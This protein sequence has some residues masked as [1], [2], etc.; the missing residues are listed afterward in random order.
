MKN[1]VHCFLPGIVGHVVDT[2]PNRF[3]GKRFELMA[4]VI[5]AFLCERQWNAPTMICYYMKFQHHHELIKN[6]DTENYELW[7][8]AL[9]NGI[10]HN[11]PIDFAIYA[12]DGS[13]LQEFQLK[14]FG[15]VRSDTDELIAYINAM[16]NQYAPIDATC[17]VWVTDIAAIDFLKVNNEMQ[18]ADFPFTALR[19]FGVVEDRNILTVGLLPEEGWSKFDIKKLVAKYE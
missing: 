9:E 2:H 17:L 15:M 8:D 18:K 12:A 16:K 13:G 10:D 19:F 3:S 11:Q 5:M 6:A 1:L 7:L 4:A 14:R